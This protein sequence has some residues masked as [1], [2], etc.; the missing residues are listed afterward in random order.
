[1]IIGTIGQV[2][3][4]NWAVDNIKGICTSDAIDR[5]ACPFSQT[6]FD[7]SIIGGGI[8][9]RWFFS[10]ESGYRSLFCLSSADSCAS[11]KF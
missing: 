10:P 2:A 8:G 6:D 7:T 4:V 3:I 5:C 11:G 9:P 1:M